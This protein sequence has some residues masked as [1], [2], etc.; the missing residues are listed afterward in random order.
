MGSVTKIAWTRST[1]NPWIGCTEVSI[2]ESGGGG[3][4]ACYA[5]EL[6][7]RHRYGGATHWGFGVPRY[8][9]KP[10]YWEHPSKWDM[11]SANERLAE[12]VRDGDDWNG[13]VG[14]WPVFPSMCDPFDNEVP[15]E[16]HADFWRLI[17]ATPNLT[18]LLLTKRIANVEKMHPGG[19][20]QNVWIGASVV[21]QK[22]ANRDIPK[23]RKIE[24]FAK[25]FVSH[26][27]ALGGVG[28][29]GLLGGV[30]Q[31]IT[32]GESRQGKCKARLFRACWARQ[33][34]R[35]CR[36]AGVAFFMKQMGSFVVDRNDAGFDGCDYGA[37]PLNAD[38]SERELDHE[39]YGYE[40]KYQGADCRVRLKDR[41]GADPSEW[42][43]DLRVREFPQ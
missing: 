9:T 4:D 11:E 21:N 17:R 12:K 30:S 8:R 18:W 33:D 6:D 1:F 40:E 7:R 10:A 13:P 34:M 38:G 35:A 20:Y 16:W 3:C 42:P 39:I 28:W 36:K 32:G 41:A 37:W 22:E 19:E 14:F 5:R 2:E 15:Q 29:N 27:P 43:E 25:R 26:E 31:V 23:L 24:G